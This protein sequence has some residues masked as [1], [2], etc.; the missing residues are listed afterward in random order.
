MR[1][2]WEQILTFVPDLTTEVTRQAVDGDTIWTEWEHRGTR[3]DG[4]AHLMRG[5][6]VFGV[7]DGLASWA[8]FYLEPV[9]E[10]SGDVNAAVQRQ[11]ARGP[12]Q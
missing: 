8:R 6:V 2:N 1:R 10:V 7:S 4:T 5:V 12:L 3:S 11:V 9:E